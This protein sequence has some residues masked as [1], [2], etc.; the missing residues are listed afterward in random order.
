MLNDPHLTVLLVGT[1]IDT[2]LVFLCDLFMFKLSFAEFWFVF[3]W[4][5]SRYSL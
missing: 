5:G 4:T 3:C 1:V 2:K